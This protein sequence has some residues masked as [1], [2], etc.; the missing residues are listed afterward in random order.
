MVL[1]AAELQESIPDIGYVSAFLK[2]WQRDIHSHVFF[3]LLDIAH[4]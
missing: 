4:T 2:K 3:L 1:Q